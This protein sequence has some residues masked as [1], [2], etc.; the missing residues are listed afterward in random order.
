MKFLPVN[1]LRAAFLEFFEQRGHRRIPSSSLVP[2]GDETLLFTS[3]G[4]VQFKP[5]FEGLEDPPTPRMVSLQKCFRTTDIEDAGDE[6]HLTFFEMLGNFSIGDYFKRESIEWAWEF[7]TAVLELDGERLWATVYIDDDEAFALWLEQGL[8][9]ERVLRYTAAQGN[10]WGPAGDRGAC[11]PSSEL[12]YDFRRRSDCPH[13]ADGTCHPDIECGRFLELWNLVF[14]TLYQHQDGRR[15]PLPANNVDTGAGLERLAWVLQQAD[16]VYETDELRELLRQVEAVSGRVYEPAQ[17]PVIAYALRAI[18]DHARALAFLINDG[19]LPAND[20]RGY[21]L[22]RVLRRA[23]YVA[24]TIG[25]REPF[26]GRVIDAAT[27]VAQSAY[28]ELVD[29]RDYI[30]TVVEA[31]E[32]RFQHTLARGLE[33]L[34]QLFAREQAAKVVPGKDIFRLYDRHGLPSELTAEVAAERGFSADLEGFEREMEAQRERSRGQTTFDLVGNERAQ[35]YHALG[36]ESEFRGY[37]A[38]VTQSEVIAL[39]SADQPA[40]RLEAGVDGEVVLAATSCYPEGGGQVGD[41]GEIV[42]PGGRFRVDSTREHGGAIVH[43]GAVEEGALA[44]GEAAESRVD[45]AHRAGSARNHTG[46]HLL[47]AALRSVLG[48]HVRQAGS[49]VGPDRLRFDYSHPEAPSAEQLREV[50]RLVSARIRD[51]IERETLELPYEQAIERGAIAFFEDRYTPRVRMV[52]YC[53]ARGHGHEHGAECFSRELCG[54]THLD[55]T[56][57]VG[58]LVIVGDSSIGA[59]LRRIEALTGPDAERYLGQRLD[60]VDALS[61]RFRVPVEGVLERIDALEEQLAEERRRLAALQRSAAAD[62]ADNLLAQAEQVD[63]GVCILASRVDV[64]SADEL[65]PLA[66]RLR[67]QLPSSFIVLGAEVEGRPI[68]LAACTDDV[69]ELGLRADELVREAAALIGGGGGGRP[70]LA[71]AGGRD[72]SQLDDALDAARRAA[73]E[74]LAGA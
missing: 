13:C 72:A 58:T 71:Q 41:C 39:A 19:V 7:M 54:G 21:V 36:V 8:P 69:I 46:T 63:G 45:A 37:E 59:G 66:D 47:H 11:G 25:L 18:T 48:S 23:V 24:H 49:Y 12:H 34:E 2:H 15:E 33:L 38:L 22:R 44:V 3:A 6:S 5:Y 32:A 62:V 55:S 65:R 68:L 9:P 70:Q 67:A 26:L 14:T 56:G 53:E 61:H 73:M 64:Q 20:G 10:F 28:P 52:E 31:E 1:Q 4:M 57:Q 27:E 16:S 60:L 51:D 29:Q 42:T 40:E 50:Q 43:S 74:R 35:R 30:R 17:S